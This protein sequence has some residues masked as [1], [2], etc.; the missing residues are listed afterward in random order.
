VTRLA[1]T[2]VMVL[3]WLMSTPMGVSTAQAQVNVNVNIG[4]GGIGR[5]GITC[6][7][8]RRIVERRG[9]RNVRVR[10]CQGRIFTYSGRRRGND[11]RIEVRRRDGQIVSVRRR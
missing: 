4:K 7:Q 3:A 9:F 5:S 6:G 11:F 10:S 1:M 8:G 2:L